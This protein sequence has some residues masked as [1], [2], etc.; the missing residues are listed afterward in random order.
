MG[1]CQG[2]TDQQGSCDKRTNLFKESPVSACCGV[3]D[4]KHLIT[5]KAEDWQH[6]SSKVN[7][8]FCPDKN[9]PKYDINKNQKMT[10]FSFQYQNLGNA[11]QQFFKK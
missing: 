5:T 4:I 10:S 2:S 9:Q 3:N 6:D 8:F 11:I 1:W 7:A